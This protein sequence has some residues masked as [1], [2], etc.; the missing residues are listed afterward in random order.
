MGKKLEGLIF[1]SGLMIGGSGGYFINDKNKI[2]N[3]YKFEKENRLIGTLKLKIN[4]A[5]YLP[6]GK[7][8]AFDDEG[9]CYEVFYN[10]IE[11][12]ARI[13]KSSVVARNGIGKEIDF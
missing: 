3:E 9:K 7:I 5:P 11:G 6:I 2:S 8:D 1:F 12:I 10:S 13:K 4:E